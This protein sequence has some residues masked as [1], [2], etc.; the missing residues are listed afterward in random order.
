MKKGLGSAFFV[1]VKKDIMYALF[2]TAFT[3]RSWVR[4][5]FHA[6]NKNV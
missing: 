1:N 3:A 2:M 6:G 5:F 4:S